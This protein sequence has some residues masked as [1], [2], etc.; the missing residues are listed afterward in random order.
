MDVIVLVFD[1]VMTSE[2]LAPIE[3]LTKAGDVAVRLA[4]PHPGKTWGFE[5][6]H[7]FDVGSDLD[8]TM[9]TDLVLIP[10]GLGS[11]AMM[12][13]PRVIDW[14]ARMAER[15]KYILSVS[16]GSLLLAAAGLLDD[17]DASGHWLAHEDLAKAGA[18]PSTEAV[19][20]E[21][22]IVTTSGYLAAAEAARIVRE[23]V[24]FAS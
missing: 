24:L 15:T 5:P 12:K 1:G 23:K 10:G 2:V 14:I 19:T 18:H 21:G 8:N 16:T 11:L 20:W 22:K 9:E 3:A 6:L 17:R 4:G 7:S 13:E